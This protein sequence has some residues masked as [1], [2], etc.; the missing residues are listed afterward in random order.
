MPSLPQQVLH[1]Y[2]GAATQQKRYDPLGLYF[3]VWV[4][5]E[6]YRCGDIQEVT[7][8]QRHDNTSKVNVLMVKIIAHEHADRGG[9]RKK[10][11]HSNDFGF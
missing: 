7:C 4:G 5:L 9:R 3:M 11:Q 10:Y 6:K 2:S 8:H 1:G